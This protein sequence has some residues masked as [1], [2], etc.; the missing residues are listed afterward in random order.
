MSLKIV[1]LIL[2]GLTYILLLS[3]PKHRAYVALCSAAIFVIL[4]IVPFKE[5]LSAIDWNV[6]MMIAGTMGIVSLFTESK[7]PNLLADMLIEK[8]AT[9]KW[10]IIALS[11]FAGIIS[12]FIDNVA[13]VLMIAPVALTIASKLGISPVSSIIAISIASNL[14]GAATLV[15]DTTSILLGGHA[16]MNFMDFFVFHGKMGLFWVVQLGALVSTVILLVVFRKEKQKVHA[17]ERTKVTNY[18]PSILLVAMV[19]L[20]IIASFIPNTP[21]T[22]NGIICVSLFVVGLI[23]NVIRTKSPDMVTTAFA[24]IDYFTILLLCGLFVV[25][26]GITNVGVV[27]DIS[28]LFVRMSGDNLFLIYTLIVWASVLFSAF[29]DNIPYVATMLPVCGEIAGLMG[30][31][32]YILYFGLLVG[33]TL[34]GNLTP[35]GASANITGIGILRK[36]GYEVSAGQF[37]KISVPFTL[38]AVTTGYILVWLLWS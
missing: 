19:L 4:G 5:V 36:E 6:I 31:S 33:S 14:Q 23:E 11:L 21:K 18:F 38:A 30:V 8:T 25:I 10:A 17:M 26:G 20:L 9:V 15:G 2:F 35:I 32:P 3:L 24:E 37:M 22:I 12:A 16:D 27:T 34:G 1:A 28:N 7:M 29:I 13:T